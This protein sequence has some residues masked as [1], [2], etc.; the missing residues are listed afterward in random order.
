MLVEA[1]HRALLR[2]DRAVG[3]AG[4]AVLLIVGVEDLLVAAGVRHAHLVLLAQHR[5]EVAYDKHHLARSVAAQERDDALLAVVGHDP[6]EALPAVIDLPQGGRVTV[7]V[8]QIPDVALQLTVLIVA[9]QHPVERLLLV[10]LDKLAEVLAHKE[11]LFAGMGHHVAKEGAQVREFFLI[12]AG[13]LVQQAALAVDDL[14]VADGQHEVLTERIEEAER[15]LAVVAG[16]EERVGFHVAEHVV[17]PAHVPLEI[18]A[19]APVGRGLCD[20][21]PG[22]GF[23]G[24]HHFMRIAAQNSRVQL[25]QEGDGLEIFLAAVDVLL[26]LAVLAVVVEIEHTGDSIDAQTVHMIA[27]HPEHGAG[28][29]EALDLL[30]AVVKDH[31]APFLVLTA[32]GVGILI[33][34]GAVEHVQ[35]VAILREVGRDPVQND[36]D[37]RLMQLVDEGHEVL[38]RAVAACRGKIA[39]DLIA[40]AAVEGI[41][42]DGQQ[43]HMGVAH[44]LY[45]RDQLVGQLGI[46][47]GHAVFGVLHLPAA[48]LQ[49]VNGHRAVD[50]IP[51]F[52]VTDPGGIPPGVAL[53]IIDLAAVGRAGLGME[54]IRVSL[55][56]QLICRGGDAVFI[57]IKLF[58]AGNEALP[59]TV[60]HLFHGVLAGRPA[61][62]VTHNGNS[63]GVR[64]PDTEHRAGLAV[65]LAQM[66]T[67]VAIGLLIVALLEQINGQIGAFG[68]FFALFQ[69]NLP[70]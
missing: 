67:E 17:H 41:L 62:E 22:G 37:A 28:D 10:P 46:V 20:Q 24:D 30:H 25:L 15:D 49:L 13:H 29:Q 18:E 58:D 59:D 9:E 1:V 64:C 51:L 2:L 8:V 38:R 65:F 42:G 54:G 4:A 61:V 34:G 26:P 60:R 43:L 55:I 35:A 7:E 45:V 14:V 69:R 6:L 3:H 52:L 33:A 39:R 11:Q 44:F 32:A 19:Q 70:F 68:R 63:L 31:R 47:V 12:I 48:G 23:L 21:R 40:P 50:D 5:V 36:A 16:A 66:R 53:N 27:V 57:D 56:D